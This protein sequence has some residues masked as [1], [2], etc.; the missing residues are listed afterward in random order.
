MKIL[1]SITREK[2]AVSKAY[3]DALFS[4]YIANK[5]NQLATAR[6]IWGQTFDG[7]KDISGEL[8]NVSEVYGEKIENPVHEHVFYKWRILHSNDIL[9][10]QS[11]TTQGDR[12][13]SIALSGYNGTGADQI[14]LYAATSSVRGALAVEGSSTFKAKVTATGGLEVKQGLNVTTGESSFQYA[15]TCLNGLRVAGEGLAGITPEGGLYPRFRTLSASSGFYFQAASYDGM[16][17][18]GKIIFSGM[19]GTK[20]E[21]VLFISKKTT[22]A[23]PLYVSGIVDFEGLLTAQSG[24]LV[25]PNQTIRFQDSATESASIYFDSTMGGMNFTSA[26]TIRGLASFTKGIEIAVGQTISFVD[27]NGIKHQIAYD[28]EK[29]AIKVIG[30]FFSTGEN[31]AGGAGESI[32]A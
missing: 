15:V 2:D 31:A 10:L 20:A 23:C 32:N 18:N 7:T 17:Q 21:E 1:S 9:Y 30:N 13:G 16:S 8:S 4:G 29:G 5:A 14:S 25:T 3:V 26:T 6:K 12:G 11:G 22:F 28:E 19:Y 27:S 24:L